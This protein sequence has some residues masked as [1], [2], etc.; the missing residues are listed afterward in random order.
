MDVSYPT[1]PFESWQCWAV[2]DLGPSVKETT[3]RWVEQVGSQRRSPLG[4]QFVLLG[5]IRRACFLLE[6]FEYLLNNLGIFDAG[7]DFDLPTAVL[8]DFDINIEDALETLHPGH[9]AMALCGALVTPVGIAAFRFVGLLAPLGGCYL[10]PVFAVGRE[11]AIETCEV[12]S[13]LG[14]QRGQ[15]RHEIQWL[16]DHMGGA[17]AIRC[18]QFVTHLAI[19]RHC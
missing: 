14:Y 15:L 18:L 2:L 4:W 12:D 1:A 5:S 10:S 3:L 17:I 6:V 19:G 9:G 11:D 13:W 7:N 16:K 8:A